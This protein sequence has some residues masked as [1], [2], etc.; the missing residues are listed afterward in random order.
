MLGSSAVRLSLVA[1]P[2]LRLGTLLAL[3]FTLFLAS[4]ARLTKALV[5]PLGVVLYCAHLAGL[6]ALVLFTFHGALVAIE[7]HTKR[8]RLISSA[9]ALALPMPFMYGIAVHVAAGDGL[10]ARGVPTALTTSIGIAALSL[11]LVIVWTYRFFA[12]RRV[13][14]VLFAL[15]AIAGMLVADAALSRAYTQLATLLQMFA[16]FLA[17]QL[18]V[19]LVGDAARRQLWLGL[20]SAGPALALIAA[21]LCMPEQVASG[22]RRALVAESASAFVDARLSGIARGDVAPAIDRSRCAALIAAKPAPALALA[23]E[24]RRNVILISIDT[25]R[26]DFVESRVKNELLMPGL[27]NF[28]REARYAPRAQAAFPATMLSMTAAFS[29]FM[30]SD[31]LL[32]PKPIQNIFTLA[33]GQMDTIEALLPGGRYFTRPDVQAYLLSGAEPVPVGSARH[34]T[35]HAVSRLRELRAQGKRH[36]IWIHYYEPHG[37]YRSRPEYGFG[38]SEIDRYRAEIATVDAQLD[39]L[40]SV[41]REEGWYDD[42][43]IMLFSDHGESFGE[44]NHYHHHYLVYPWLVN[45]PLV[46]HTPGI[47]PARVTGPVHLTDVA[48]TVLHFLDLPSPGGMRGVSLLGAPPPATRPLL[49]E[50]VS[51]SGLNMHQFRLN[52]AASEAE[53]FKRLT[54]LEN[55]PGY[56]SK[57]AVRQGDYYFVQHRSSLANELYLWRKDPLAANDLADRDPARR[58][59]LNAEAKRF[60]ASVFERAACSLP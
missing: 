57:L 14:D 38:D 13:L 6:A 45:V 11:T 28:T 60:R 17:S 31:I 1:V 34:E 29:G 36:M 43:L 2:A 47:T 55:G 12:R 50:E 33:R 7:R 42:S 40:L 24:Q 44:H 19:V 52:P 27:V 9:L 18:I 49:S 4:Y 46:W 58:E 56:A 5:P 51:I 48:A 32:A 22:R 3:S 20:A 30:P 25:L 41:L 54:R 10:R 15:V 35:A 21:G 59:Q 26:A 23:P 8:G 53:L 16:L 37:P 39:R